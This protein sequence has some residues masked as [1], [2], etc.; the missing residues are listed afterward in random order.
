MTDAAAAARSA[1]AR[2]ASRT[3]R[4]R[5]P[6]ARRRRHRRGRAATG[7]SAR[8]NPRQPVDRRRHGDE[9]GG[10]DARGDRDGD[11][12]AEREA[13]EIQAPIGPPRATPLDD[14]ERVVALAD[15]IR[16]AAG[17]RADAAKI[18]PHGVRAEPRERA[19][20]RRDDLV[21]HRAL[22]ERMRM[23]D[24]GDRAT[25]GPRSQSIA[26]SSA[27]AGPAISTGS[28]RRGAASLTSRCLR[29]RDRSRAR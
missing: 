10:R 14:G 12:G 25:A 9:P 29:R 20:E 24:H 17:R 26:A 1:A 13:A 18:E 8:R 15:A 7:T 11:R 22:L 28:R 2:R 5:G 27:P 23:A 16:V 4:A 19:R 6:A 21:V 3:T